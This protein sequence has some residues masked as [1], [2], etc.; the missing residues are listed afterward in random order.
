MDYLYGL[1]GTL[2]T[3]VG[4]T[5]SA[6]YVSVDGTITA[7]SVDIEDVGNVMSAFKLSLCLLIK[8][9]AAEEQL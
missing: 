7:A 4:L 1:G 2:R 8:R 6:N 5:C 3:S 9:L